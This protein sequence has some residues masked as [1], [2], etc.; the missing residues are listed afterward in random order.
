[1]LLTVKLAFGFITNSVSILASAIDSLLDVSASFINYLSIRKSEKPADT[2]H[3]FGHGKAEGLAGLFQCSIIG[4][5]ELYLIY[6]YVIRLI[7]GGQLR[8][9]G[10]GIVVIAFSIIVSLFLIRYMRRVV[11]ETDSIALKA[12]SVH[13]LMDIYTNVGI[14]IALVIIKLTGIS[15]IDSV[16]SIFVALGIL[17]SSKDIFI[18]SLDI[19]MDKEL[20]DETVL[21]IKRVIDKYRPTVKSFNK[22][23]NRD[24]GVIKFI[25]FH[26]VM[27]HT[28]TFVKSHEIAEQI[29]IEIEEIIPNSEVTVHVDPDKHPDYS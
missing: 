11:S 14:I 23:M 3:K 17:W 13:Y 27:D 9:I 29:I 5:S 1:M 20:P 28:L 25:E 2:D 15:N 22:M 8:S 18:K 7:Y 26:L 21:I 16:V 4:I 6:L 12:D 10:S 19:L 24:A